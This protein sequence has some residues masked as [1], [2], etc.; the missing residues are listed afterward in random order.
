MGTNRKRR[1]VTTPATERDG[2]RASSDRVAIRQAERADLLE[3][4]R[5]EQ[6]T[7]PQPWPFAAFDGF[8]GERGFLVATAPGEGS[9]PPDGGVVDRPETV[10]GYVVSDLVPNH[11]RD[12]GH[13]K[14]LAVDAPYRG[15]G[16]GRRLLTEALTSLA[17]RGASVVKLEVREG[18]DPARGLYREFGFEPAQRM[19]RYYGD[20]EAALV[21]TLD[22]HE[23]VGRSGAFDVGDG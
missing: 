14:D 15:D 10:V 11:G 6:R 18:N 7:F 1:F 5:I 8:V 23:W 19:P 2:E 9:E 16:L 12:I 3:V 22:L 21:M 4:F 13:V 17:L 20:G